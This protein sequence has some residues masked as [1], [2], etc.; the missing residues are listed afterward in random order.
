LTLVFPLRFILIATL[1]QHLGDAPWAIV[2]LLKQK[3]RAQYCQTLLLSLPYRIAGTVRQNA[4][5]A[6]PM[7]ARLA[8]E[9]I[10]VSTKPPIADIVP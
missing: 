9:P 8:R 1:L 10:W 4:I 5:G 2:E 7:S 6:L 3:N